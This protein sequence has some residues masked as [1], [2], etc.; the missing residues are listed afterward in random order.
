MPERRSTQRKTVLLEARW[1]SMSRRH[2][3]RVDDVSLGQA[4][5]NRP[6]TLTVEVSTYYRLDRNGT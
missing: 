4:E 3:A 6:V 2:E 1:E 5:S